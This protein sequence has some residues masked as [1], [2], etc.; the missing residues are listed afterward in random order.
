M[1]NFKNFETALVNEAYF[2]TPNYN[3]ELVSPSLLKDIV[4]SADELSSEFIS[5]V[6]FKEIS[7]YVNELTFGVKFISI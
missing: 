6:D 2:D 7:D 5:K 4:E 1:K 3:E